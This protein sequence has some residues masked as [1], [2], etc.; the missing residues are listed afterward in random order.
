MNCPEN[1]LFNFYLHGSWLLT[2]EVIGHNIFICIICLC[3]EILN[4][5]FFQRFNTGHM[6]L[7]SKNVFLI[8]AIEVLLL[9]P[10]FPNVSVPLKLA[11]GIQGPIMLHII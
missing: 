1:L 9:P 7:I 11:K 8:G 3:L 6:L 4:L 10:I 2:P 5:A